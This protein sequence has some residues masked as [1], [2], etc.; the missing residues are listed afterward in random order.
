MITKELALSCNKLGYKIDVI[1]AL[2]LKAKTHDHFKMI[3]LKA[4]ALV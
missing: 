4:H 1:V 2:I 3:V